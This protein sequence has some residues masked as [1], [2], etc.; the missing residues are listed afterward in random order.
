[1]QEAIELSYNGK[2][3]RGMMHIPD[4]INKNIPIVIMFHG[5]TGN[6]VESHFIF[7][8]LSR[9]LE[10]AGIS[11]VR[12]DFYGSGES[13]GDFSEMT[14]SSE[15]EDARQILKFVKDHFKNDTQK[16][17]L[18]GLSMGGAIAGII[19][20]E[21]KED[22]SALVLWAPAFNMPDIIGNQGMSQYGT[23]MEKYGFVDIGGHKLSKAFVDDILKYNIYS[24]SKGFGKKVLLVHGTNDT[25][26]EYKISDKILKEV[27][28]G[29]AKR[30]TIEDADHTFTNLQWEKKAIDESVDFFKKELNN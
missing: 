6:K 7:V 2:K 3:L 10:K 18:L 21:Y 25:S 28:V 23:I 26:V 15:L 22:I 24:L 16:I 30:I 8:K 11:S 1:M 19:A 12:F 17:G 9:F 4:S 14:F 29:N 5:F 13:D 27:Y 20:S